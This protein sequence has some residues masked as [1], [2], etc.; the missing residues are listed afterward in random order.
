MITK[1]TKEA[2][3][4]NNKSLSPKIRF[5]GFDEQWKKYK[6]GEI[7]TFINGRAYS[8]EE[9]LDSGKYR[10]LRVGNFYTNDS[11]YYSDLELDE[12]YYATYGDLLYTWSATFGPHIWQGEKVIYHYHIW[13][14][15]LSKHLEKQ[16]AVQLLE[17][18]KATIL[19]DKNGSTMVHITKAGMEGKTV[20]VPSNVEE[21]KRIGLC[22]NKIDSLIFLSKNKYEKLFAIKKSLLE[23]MIPDNNCCAP[24]IRFKGYLTKWKSHR[25]G[26]E[27]NI[28]AGGTPSTSID[29]YWDNG[30]INWLPSGNVQDCAINEDDIV[31][32]ITKKGLENSSAKLIKPD[33]ALLAMTGATCGKSGYLACYS[34]ANQSVMAFE[35][36]RL[37][38][39]FLFYTFQKNK[40]YILQHQAGGGQAGINKSTCSN[41]EF[42]FPE[43]PEQCMISLFLTKLDDLIVL[44]QRK[45]EKLNKI[46]QA[47][48]N[49]MFI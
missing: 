17:Q 41:F 48:I 5:D 21:Q 3:M 36:T 33:T 14:I 6:L 30:D 22:F 4:A 44:Y 29:E 15:D 43:K 42:L 49:E 18:D 13:K 23:A 10:V 11:W 35:T 47:L 19:S 32:K 34:S 25:L 12:K 7:A 2:K 46:K 26:D 40:D 9:L 45:Y 20:V 1:Q 37:D 31:T 39:K 38:S 28:F 8:Q 27:C 24:T 16:F